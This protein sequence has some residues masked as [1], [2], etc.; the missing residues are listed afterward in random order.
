MGK[1]EANHTDLNM[2]QKIAVEHK[3]GPLLVVAGAGTGKTTVI[4][5]KISRMLSQG[6]D[7][8]SILAVTFTEK[9]AAEMLDRLVSSGVGLQPEIAITTFNSFGESLLREF[10]SHIGIGRNFKLLSEQA[11]IVFMRERIDKFDLDYFLPLTK[12]PD[13]ILEDIMRLFSLAKQHIVTP[14]DFVEYAKNLTSSE[15]SDKQQKR[16]YLELSK[17]YETYIKLCREENVIDY[18]DQIYLVIELLRSR[19]NIQ[20]LLQKRFHTIF[21]DEF[22]DTN[23]MQSYLMDMLVDSKQNMVV[24]GDD[25]QSIYGF[26]GATLSNILSFKDRYPES[27][28]VALT[29]NFRSSQMILDA[30][31][32]LIQHNNPNRLETT[33]NLDKHLTGQKLGIP[34]KLKRFE[35][36][37]EEIEWLAQDIAERINAGETPGSIAVLARSRH[38]ARVVY[39]TLERF[40]I[41]NKLIGYRQDLY[42]QPVVRML[43]ELCRTIAEPQNNES[44]HHTLTSNIFDISNALIAPFAAQARAEHGALKDIL[45]KANDSQV[46]NA[47]SHV[48]DWRNNASSI[49]V[50]RLLYRA[51]SDSGYKD[52]LLALAQDDDDAALNM[53]ALAQYFDTLWEFESIAIQPTVAQ[54]LVSLPALRSAGEATEDGTLEIGTNEVNVMTVHKSKGLEWDTVYIPDCTEMSFPS[55]NQPRGLSLPDELKANS[56]SPADEHY[57]E[58][59]RLMYVAITRARKN[60]TISFSEHGKSLAVR[61][62]SRFIDE[63]FGNGTADSISKTS[64]GDQQ[65]SLLDLPVATK[66]EISVPGNIYD[67]SLVLLSVSQAACLLECPQ[68]FYYKY[69]LRA[70]EDPSP[71][72]AYGTQLHGL[73]QAINEGIR[74]NKLD[75]LNAYLNDLKVGWQKIGYE[76]KKHQERAY[77]Q[78]VKTLTRFYHQAVSSSPPLLVEESFNVKLAPEDILL[79]G[80]YDVVLENNGIEIRDYKT[81]ISVKTA[82][83]AKQRATTSTQLTLYALAWQLT[84]DEFPARLSLHFVD[85]DIIGTVRKTQKGIDGLRARLAKAVSDLKTGEFPLGNQRHNYCI[86]PDSNDS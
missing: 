43:C 54:Y 62:P 7:P 76:S 82:E 10:S 69:V 9:A 65:Q 11:Q 14:A 25:D 41:P 49:S 17:A 63:M 67:G 29:E 24:V 78:A 2:A 80:R 1:V 34:P 61:K 81:S 66:Q 27:K 12:M 33:L 47:L 6:I 68:N 52:R 39:E 21:I 42:K 70:P 60:L 57:A 56:T 23:P 22:Q 28:E 71:R 8:K 51:I 4:V 30:A 36:L 83:K 32:A 53:Q 59:R 19:P 44:L 86:H 38:T 3:E 58:E 26:R 15:E 31:Y 73:F 50:G 35:Q 72:T 20:K 84:H 75:P 13:A 48:Q 64:I 45:M 77:V 16:Q 18:D 74:D 40:G 46:I 85:T 55:K 79:R 37:G 5:E